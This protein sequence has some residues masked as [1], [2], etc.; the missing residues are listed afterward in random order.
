MKLYAHNSESLTHALQLALGAK[1]RMPVGWDNG[2]REYRPWLH[3]KDPV[4]EARDGCIVP[5]VEFD[6]DSCKIFESCALEAQRRR[7]EGD[8]RHKLLIANLRLKTGV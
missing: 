8:A 3:V 1:E 6:H 2:L 5:L 7:R 4:A